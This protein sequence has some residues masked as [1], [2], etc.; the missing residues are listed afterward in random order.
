RN[1]IEH[2]VLSW[3]KDEHPDPQQAKEAVGLFLETLGLERCQAIWALHANTDNNHIHI[4][5]NRID[6]ATGK[7]LQAGDGWDIDAAHRAIA[8]IEDRQGWKREDGALYFARQ[9]RLFDARTNRPVD[10]QG[11][12]RRRQEVEGRQGDGLPS[13]QRSALLEALR[14]AADWQDL[15][16]RLARLDAAYE[17]KGS[18]AV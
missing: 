9:G 15:H 5:V 1:P 18:G 17:R 4:M 16:R 10:K 3:Q 14:D 2:Y 13:E 11:R 7:A 6:S 8:L 12:G